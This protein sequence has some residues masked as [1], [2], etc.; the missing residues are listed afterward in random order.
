[1]LGLINLD[2]TLHIHCC[3]FNQVWLWMED[4]TTLLAGKKVQSKT[5][6]SAPNGHQ[7][8]RITRI[9]SSLYW[10][11]DLLQLELYG[12]K[13]DALKKTQHQRLHRLYGTK[14]VVMRF[15]TNFYTSDCFGSFVTCKLFFRLVWSSFVQIAQLTQ[16]QR[17]RLLYKHLTTNTII[18]TTTSI[19]CS[20]LYYHG[21]L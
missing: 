21:Y 14:P 15:Q 12:T 20:T 7:S 17:H 13:S 1:M 2:D 8:P 11:I 19:T 5:S 16:K 10:E 9:E 3:R 4:T 18:I 6:S